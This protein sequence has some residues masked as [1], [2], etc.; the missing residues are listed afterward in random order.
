[1][2]RHTLRPALRDIKLWNLRSYAKSAS[3]GIDSSVE[4]NLQTET[5]RV[6]KTLQK[7]WN[8]VSSQ[9]SERGITITLDSKPV[10][11]PLG[12]ALTVSKDRRLLALVLENEW[13]NLASLSI[14]PHSLPVTSIVSRCIDL[15]YASRPDS[16]AD[17]VA[18]IGGDRAKISDTLLRYLDTDT[19][20]CLSPSAEFE[21]ALRAAQNK[22]YLPIINAAETFLSK[23]SNEP[24]SIAILDADLHGLRGN[25]QSEATKA[26]ALKYLGS[27]SLWDLA[28]F[29]NTV[30]TTKSFMCGLLLLANKALTPHSD[31][32]KTMEQL[33]QCATLETIYQ[34]ER[35]GEVEDT[36]DVDY[37]DV[38][39]KTNAA[40]IVAYKE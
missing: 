1:M 14:K 35:W 33:A 4:N 17:L 38:R 13:A 23:F 15:E 26:A 39:R 30:L 22:L 20:L 36:H 28:V 25:I 8:V 34:V 6:S 37:R 10:R 3:L 40:A 18:K 9:E 32:S 29:E 27:L 24:V 31:L 21:G 19:L 7:F 5:N 11:T 2:L 12:N 16:D